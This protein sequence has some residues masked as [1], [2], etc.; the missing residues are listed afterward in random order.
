MCELRCD[1]LEN[2]PAAVWC[3]GEKL[4]ASRCGLESCLSAR[5]GD[6]GSAVSRVLERVVSPSGRELGLVHVQVLAA[7]GVHVLVH[8]QHLEVLLQGLAAGVT[9]DLWNEIIKP[10]IL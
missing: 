7:Q 10:C 1:T 8:E 4:P 6:G 2:T 5:H 9:E 3:T